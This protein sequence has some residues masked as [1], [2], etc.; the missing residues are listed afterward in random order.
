M[1]TPSPS[2]S[3]PLRWASVA[4]RSR[5][6]QARGTTILRP[7]INETTSSS[8][9]TSTAVARAL[10]S[11]T[12]EL[13]PCL[14]EVLP[15]FGHQALH[16]P[17]LGGRESA[18]GGESHRTEPELRDARFVLHMHM[19]RLVA[20]VAVE[21]AA[22]RSDPGNSWQGRSPSSRGESKHRA[23]REILRMVARGGSGSPSCSTGGT[24]P[25]SWHSWT[26]LRE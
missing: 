9:V 25:S 11:A 2:S 7:S 8:W 20:L 16:G 4:W 3:Q 23:S 26:E 6:N 10:A 1:P 17:Q 21:E 24:A 14:Q 22:E 18:G 19:G 12:E 13:I 15:L 5:G